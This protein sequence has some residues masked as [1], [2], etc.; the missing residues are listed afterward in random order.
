MSSIWNNFARAIDSIG[1]M[2][3]IRRDKI[4]HITIPQPPEYWINAELWPKYYKLTQRYPTKFEII[5]KFMNQFR[6]N[7]IEMI[8]PFITEIKRKTIYTCNC[9]KPCG[10]RQKVITN[11][12]LDNMYLFEAILKKR[13]RIIKQANIN[14]NDNIYLDLEYV[15]PLDAGKHNP[16]PEHVKFMYKFMNKEFYYDTQYKFFC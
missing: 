12:G 2:L 16:L 9:I 6:Q 5:L 7:E 11:D 15:I 14:T 8:I 4:E 13:N 1:A 10:C 3:G